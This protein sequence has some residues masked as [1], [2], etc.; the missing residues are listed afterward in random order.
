ML[1]CKEPALHPTLSA[2]LS[3]CICTYIHIFIAIIYI[4]LYCTIKHYIY[5]T[6]KHVLYGIGRY[7]LY[8]MY[9][10]IHGPVSSLRSYSTCALCTDLC[11][12]PLP[13]RVLPIGE[14]LPHC[15]S[16]APYITG[17]GEGA[18]VDRLWSIP[19]SVEREG[20]STNSS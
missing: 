2:G 1:Q 3:D 20:G 14:H 7:T 12:C 13:I 9:I 19:C 18:V 6:Y 17:A 8:V 4:A 16:V 10:H 15:D 5:S 11:A